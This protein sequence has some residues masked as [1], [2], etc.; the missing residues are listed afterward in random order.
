[1]YDGWQCAV[2]SSQTKPHQTALYIKWWNERQTSD[3]KATNESN[4]NNG[5]HKVVS[6][7]FVLLYVNEMKQRGTLQLTPQQK[8]SEMKGEE[9]KME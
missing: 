9:E 1:M 5:V 7:Q 6:T 3:S 4:G 2:K 8:I